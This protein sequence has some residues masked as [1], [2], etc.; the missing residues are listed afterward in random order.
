MGFHRN[1]PGSFNPIESEV[2][3]RVFWVI[4]KMDTYVGALL[5][6]PHTI[7]DDD[8]DQELP[9]EVDDEYITEKE[10]LPMPEGKVS[11]IQASNAHT[12][13]VAIIAKI[14][15]V[16]Y[17][18][19]SSGPRPNVPGAASGY[20]VG[21]EKVRELEVELQQWFTKLPMGLRPGGE[22]PAIIIR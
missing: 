7:N 11:V 6:L 2:R 8:V 14:V 22:A 10:I 20:T 5:G 17:P 15:K 12:T 9:A 13:L 3:K 4:H 16:V 18:L 21:Y 1:L 19:K